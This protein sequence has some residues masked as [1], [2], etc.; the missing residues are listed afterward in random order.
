MLEISGDIF[1]LELTGHYDALCIT[2]NG[3]IKGNGLA[4]MGAGIAK[5]AVQNYPSI[6]KRL[7]NKLKTLGNHTHH[8]GV[9]TRSGT[10]VGIISFPTKEHWRDDSDINLIAQ[11]ARELVQLC[12]ARGYSKVLLPRP[13]TLNG[14][15][16]WSDVKPV[17][18]AILD[19]RF[20]V[21]K[22]EKGMF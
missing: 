15:L 7:A 19:D 21:V 8:L 20:I 2:T 14:K 13:G 12:N 11:S 10:N 9:S 18:A 3:I 22:Y 5:Q 4:V 6:D 16:N 17:I 1:Q